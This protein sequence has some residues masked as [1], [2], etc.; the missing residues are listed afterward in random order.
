MSPNITSYTKNILWIAIFIAS[1]RSPAFGQKNDCNYNINGKILDK[2]NNQA[3]PYV[4]VK[5]RNSDKYAIS[6]ENGYFEINDLCSENNTLEVSCIGY[7]HTEAQH[8]QHEHGNTCSIFIAQKISDLNEVIVVS[9]KEKNTGT[10]TISQI[11]ID[12][13]DIGN[14]AASLASS[15]SQIEGVTFTSNG[16]NV[17]LPVIHGL[18]GNRILILNNGLKHGFQNWGA[19]HAPEI[20][21]SAA[22]S[23]AVIKGAGGV[24]YG[25]EA[26]GGVILVK[27]NPLL[28]NTSLYGNAGAGLITNGRGGNTNVEVGYGAEKFSFFANGN[29]TKLGDR[30]TP[31]YIL[32]NTAKEETALSLG[33]L[34]HTHSFDFKLYYSYINQNLGLLRASFLSAPEQIRRAF[35]EDKPLIINPFTYNINEPNQKIRHNFAKAEVDWWLENYGKLKFVIGYQNNQRQEF[36]VRRNANLPIIDLNLTTLNTQLEWK[37]PTW[38][39]IDGIVGIEYFSQE[40]NNNPGTL[41][42]PFIPNYKSSRWSSFIIEKLKINN[43]TLEAGI[44]LDWENNIVAGRETNK[45]IFRDNFTFTN[46]T[47]SLGYALHINEFRDFKTNFGTAF[48]TPNVAELYSFGQQNFRHTFGLLRSG[49]RVNGTPT[50][51]GVTSFNES[52]V[53]LEKGYQLTNEF[54]HNKNGNTHLVTGYVNYIDNYVFD[55]PISVTQGI[56]GPQ[57]N[58]FYD[59]SETLFLG[60]DYTWKKQITPNL[61]TKLGFNYLWSRDIGRDQP[62]IEQAPIASNLQLEWKQGDFGMLKNSTWKISPSYTFQQFQAPRTV[63]VGE[64]IDRTEIITKDSEIFDFTDAPDGYFLLDAA[65]DFSVKKWNVSLSAENL[66]NQ[67]YRNYLND[68]RY[69][70]DELGINMTLSLN[71]KF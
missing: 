17:Q 71:Y 61:S 46:I 60:I 55:R 57:F 5:I 24:R 9:K 50:T 3:V 28:L 42:T 40:N 67:S 12:K 1:I 37:H 56:R 35:K 43:N 29:Y 34:Y 63:A 51:A 32:S 65:W 68:L 41:T 48:R 54:R 2:K 27:P 70:A 62:I 13:K 26:L 49:F 23:I 64:L 16:A 14:P 44:R 7:C 38:H 19:E 33:A 15:L 66:L 69:F 18:S 4:T 21:I 58:F 8:H 59:Q 10:E 53:A 47:A 45:N 36:D 31:E 52:D 6:D 39:G 20:D 22:N 11:S 25:P 30:E